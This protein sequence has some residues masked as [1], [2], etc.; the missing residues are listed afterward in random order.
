MRTR[1]QLRLSP[2]D[3]QLEAARIIAADP[4]RYGGDQALLVRWAREHI[5]RREPGDNPLPP[6]KQNHFTLF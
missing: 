3:G 2:R 5:R 4:A 6:S 1:R